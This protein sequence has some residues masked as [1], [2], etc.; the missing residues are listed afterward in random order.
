MSEQAKDAACC[1]RISDLRIRQLLET[2][3]DMVAE[4][5]TNLCYRYVSTSYQRFLGL[6]AEELAETSIVDR[7]HPEDITVAQT[8]FEE[9][10]IT[11][12][13]MRA[14]FRY[15]HASG[16]YLW[17]EVAAVPL[18]TEEATTGLIVSKR[19]LTER[20]RS[21]K[22]VYH[23]AYYDPLTDLPNRTL[24]QR[25]LAIA[26]RKAT[27]TNTLFGVLYMDLDRFK[28]INDLVGHVGGDQLLKEVAD[29]L[30]RVVG[31][32]D[33]LARTGGDEFALLITNA[34]DRQR[35][36]L[37]AEEILKMMRTP[38]VIHGYEFPLSFSIGIVM[39]P[40]DG[41]T[42][43]E[44]FKN[45]DR[46]MYVAKA[47]GRNTYCFYEH[48]W[49]KQLKERQ[50]IESNLRHAL[51]RKQLQLYY[52]PQFDTMTEKMIGVEVLIRWFHPEL[53]MI[54]PN[55]FI[56]IAEE[57]GLILPIGEWV[58]RTACRQAKEWQERGFDP[59]RVAINLSPRQFQQQNL[60]ATVESALYT[61][62]LEPQWL[63]LEIT[64][65]LAMKDAEFT[66]A[67]LKDLRAMGVSLMIDDFG[68]G[69]SSLS[70]LMRFP[71][72]GLKIDNSFVR[73][74]IESNSSALLLA[75]VITL[76]RNLNMRVIAEGVETE[77]QL[78]F[79]RKHQCDQVQGYLLGR[80]MPAAD[81]E[82]QLNKVSDD[83][84]RFS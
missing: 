14:E 26:L 82:K 36:I 79:L 38:W 63:E 71:V 60:V 18:V 41:E 45:G 7:V 43:E 48:Q 58:L 25:Q 30:K 80:P 47:Q 59:V 31:H 24:L 51:E 23:L 27:A 6:S 16:E 83:D 34:R 17:L 1:V 28:T 5:D 52:Q 76:G 33:F 35:L 64:E 15:R 22:L 84:D 68:T 74:S 37:R 8:L 10:L 66:I 70:Y 13:P 32:G 73:D 29:R 44:L 46:A 4:T 53:G 42:P 65:S 69:Y 9:C 57:T 50:L 61:S 2:L 56:P 72:E 75:S 78:T 40:G 62:G 49:E 19:D 21:Q 77:K 12:V 67:M 11:R 20:Q 54:P 55:H 3:D 39:Y 81:L